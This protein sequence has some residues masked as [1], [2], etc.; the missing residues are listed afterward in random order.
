MTRHHL[1]LY[2]AIGAA[3][4]LASLAAVAMFASAAGP[5]QEGHVYRGPAVPLGQ[6]T[7][8][9]WVA[10][11]EDGEPDALGVSISEA[12]VRSVETLHAAALTLDFPPE[13]GETGFDHVLLNWNP[14]GHPPMHVWDTPHFDFHFY[15]IPAA[16]REAIS[17]ADPEFKT[18]AERRPDARFVPVDYFMEE[19]AVPAMGVHWADTHTPELHGKPFTHTLIY[20]GW[21][22]VF[23]FVEP[24]VDKTVLDS[25]ETVVAPVKQAAAVAIP[26][27]YPT[28][29]RIDFEPATG[30]HRIVLEGLVARE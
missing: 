24:M 4:L 28:Q 10:V 8:Q 25:R 19:G 1:Y 5:A 15:M 22:G 18:K 23:N 13:A 30:E 20:G 29:Y 26:G 11:G 21:D 2:G 17:D 14:H 6:G 12:A 7:A 3:G 27:F 9:A 16:V